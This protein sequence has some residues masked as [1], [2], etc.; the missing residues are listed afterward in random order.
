MIDLPF[1]AC[2]KC[3]EG[4]ALLSMQIHSVHIYYFTSFKF[5]PTVD[6]LCAFMSFR[7]LS[8]EVYNRCQ[9]PS[10]KYTG[11]KRMVPMSE[12]E[13]HSLGR[14]GAVSHWR[15][16]WQH[17]MLCPVS[18]AMVI[19]KLF[20]RITFSTSMLK[21]VCI[22]IFGRHI[23]LEWLLGTHRKKAVLQMHL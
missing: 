6:F 15:T 23:S 14:E 2:C 9:N 12:A 19:S 13:V 21:K 17:R 4:A 7:L 8:C 3:Y 10:S 16:K 5:C 11:C 20:S 18:P 1:P 22:Y